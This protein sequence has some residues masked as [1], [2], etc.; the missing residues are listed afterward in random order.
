MPSPARRRLAHG[1]PLATP[2]ATWPQSSS[3]WRAS[4]SRFDPPAISGAATT[5]E[6]QRSTCAV[7]TVGTCSTATLSPPRGTRVAETTI[8]RR[9]VGGNAPGK[10][11]LRLDL[12]KEQPN[13]EVTVRCSYCD[14]YVRT[15]SARMAEVSAKHRRHRHG[16]AM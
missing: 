5:A 2:K 12:G 16:G 6:R 15:T 7:E 11:K 1:K 3:V 8:S 14:W 4:K 9:A 13:A 10:F